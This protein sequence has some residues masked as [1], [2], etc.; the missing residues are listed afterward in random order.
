MP[1]IPSSDSLRNEMTHLR[2]P[3]SS[4]IMAAI[5]S[6]VPE[7]AD[8][9]DKTVPSMLRRMAGSVDKRKSILKHA[10]ALLRPRFWG[11]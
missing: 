4:P 8:V 2:A 6:A 10:S 9:S 7:L 3:A 11:E 1:S 5:P